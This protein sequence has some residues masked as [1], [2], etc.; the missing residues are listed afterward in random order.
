ML[1]S[2]NEPRLPSRYVRSWNRLKFGCITIS[3]LVA[4]PVLV[5]WIVW[6]YRDHRLVSAAA[7]AGADSIGGLLGWPFGYEYHIGFDT[8]PTH[9]HLQTL[10][11]LNHPPRGGVVRVRVRT[12]KANEDD[13]RRIS[14]ALHE[15]AVF[16]VCEGGQVY[17][18]GE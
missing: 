18:P 3:L 1:D 6:S 16:Q 12:C 11:A 10:K 8:V 14:A 5:D 13:M 17:P 9:E 7:A 2:L 4:I 15:C